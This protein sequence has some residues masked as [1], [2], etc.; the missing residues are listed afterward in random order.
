MNHNWYIRKVDLSNGYTGTVWQCDRCQ[1][2]TYIDPNVWLKDVWLNEV[3]CDLQ[4]VEKI[5]KS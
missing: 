1:T 2:A 5:M 4:V 3:S